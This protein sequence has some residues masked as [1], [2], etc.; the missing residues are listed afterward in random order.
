MPHRTNPPTPSEGESVTSTSAPLLSTMA[1]LNPIWLAKK[2]IWNEPSPSS[3]P[4]LSIFYTVLTA[5]AVAHEPLNSSDEPEPPAPINYEEDIKI[6]SPDDAA[7][8]NI[9]CGALDDDGDFSD[10]D[11]SHDVVPEASYKPWGRWAWSASHPLKNIKRLLP[12]R[13]GARCSAMLKS[14]DIGDRSMLYIC[15]NWSTNQ[16][17]FWNS[18]L[19]EFWMYDSRYH[20]RALQGDVVPYLI[21]THCDRKSCLMVMEPPHDSFWIEASPDMPYVLKE[22]VVEA[23]AKL[24]KRGVLHGNPQMRHIL[25]GGDARVTIID[26]QESRSRQPV[27]DMSMGTTYSHDLNLEMRRVK[28]MLDYDGAREYE[29][30]KRKRVQLRMER[31]SKLRSLRLAKDRGE[32]LGPI[33]E[34]EIPEDEDLLNPVVSDG[35]WE[36]NW[37]GGIE[38]EPRRVVVP[39]Q[40]PE[41]L[42]AA[43]QQFQTI[44]E[45]METERQPVLQTVPNEPTNP[46]PRKRRAPSPEP[47]AFPAKRTRY[48]DREFSYPYR[49][50]PDEQSQFVFYASRSE[51][52]DEPEPDQTEV[53]NAE[54]ENLRGDTTTRSIC[55]GSDELPPA[56]DSSASAPKPINVRDFA[57]EPYVGRRGFYVPHPP[58]EN[59]MSAE[60]IRYIQQT[61]QQRCINLGLDY[62]SDDQWTCVAPNFKRCREPGSSVSLGHLKRKRAYLLEPGLKDMWRQRRPPPADERVLEELVG[63]YHL[64]LANDAALL[65]KDEVDAR[66]RARVVASPRRLRSSAKNRASS[67]ESPTSR[68]SILRVRTPKKP[69]SGHVKDWLDEGDLTHSPKIGP[70]PMPVHAW[71]RKAILGA[72]IH[73]DLPIC[74][75]PPNDDSDDDDI[76]LPPLRSS[77]APPRKGDAPLGS[78]GPSTPLD[79]ADIERTV[80]NLALATL[81]MSDELPST[82][83][84]GTRRARSVGLT[85][86]IKR[87][88][89][90]SAPYPSPVQRQGQH[91]R[92][93]RASCPP[94]QAQARDRDVAGGIS[95]TDSGVRYT[96]NRK[97]TR[98]SEPRLQ[99][100]PA[101]L[102]L[103]LD[104]FGNAV[105]SDE[106]EES[107]TA[108]EEEAGSAYRPREGILA[109][110]LSWCRWYSG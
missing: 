54:P 49:I 100:V 101:A 11:S 72:Y 99:Q 73:P 23:Y 26:F 21:K 59:R 44:V 67:P 85:R 3:S 61:N 97:M 104:V 93:A 92:Y 17:F 12:L 4:G 76:S 37:I 75:P 88:T 55:E 107:T 66:A 80:F 14:C 43:I 5:T 39:G 109:T 84:S 25:I 68:K 50:R 16:R 41:Q 6:E 70:T 40:S 110:I 32:Y 87:R 10:S 36:E 62:F 60:R 45:K 64:D 53:M 8:D 28:F 2:S 91:S 13:E 95:R 30:A 94:P 29:I 35:E 86:T 47:Y 1:T 22:R 24:H 52:T 57:S 69:I 108:A 58:T 42:A 38:H 63:P 79:S 33:E 19:E 102:E 48:R 77:S 81:G 34:E 9:H 65:T 71:E 15:K 105:Y 89:N 96:R 56:S 82:S 7:P 51:E 106:P 83:S 98:D 46:P 74:R 27:D 31:N 18:F 90:K 103:D 20:L 78:D